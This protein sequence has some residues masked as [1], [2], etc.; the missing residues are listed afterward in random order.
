M[1]EEFHS[2]KYLSEDK[3]QKHFTNLVR[4]M[5]KS[6]FENLKN[7]DIKI[8]VRLQNLYTTNNRVSNIQPV[9]GIIEMDSFKMLC[10]RLGSIE[11]RSGD[12]Y[13]RY[14]NA[15]AKANTRI[16]N[17]GSAKKNW[18]YPLTLYHHISI[19]RDTRSYLL[20]MYCTDGHYET[21]ERYGNNCPYSRSN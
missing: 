3:Q 18:L 4:I 2:R 13:S 14:N 8:D 6:D 9:P 15:M 11:D 21:Q 16:S 17:R 10:K 19:I 5:N 7:S 20:C 12:N 1:I